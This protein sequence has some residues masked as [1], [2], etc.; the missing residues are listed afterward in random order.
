M[1][2]YLDKGGM[3]KCTAPAN[4]CKGGTQGDRT[5][6]IV[7]PLGRLGLGIARTPGLHTE[8]LETVVRNLIFVPKRW[9]PLTSCRM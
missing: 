7:A 2:S 3:G 8:G 6:A 1:P 5:R 4:S 9:D